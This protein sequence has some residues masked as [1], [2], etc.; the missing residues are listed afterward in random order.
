MQP[1]AILFDLDGTLVARGASIRNYATQFVADF[2]AKLST[3]DLDQILSVLI[4]A[5]GHG[6]RSLDRPI[7][8]AGT[9]LKGISASAADLHWRKYFPSSAVAAPM[10]TEV[11]AELKRRGI[12]TGL[13]TNG[14]V[15]AQRSKLETL[16]WTD[17]FVSLVI[18]EE[19]NFKKPD[20]R[21][22]ELALEQLK[23]HAA[24]TWF[25]GDHPINDIWG[26]NR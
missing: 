8:I 10:A 21:I 5:D 20:P 2:S 19:H 26:L 18:S 17:K 14:S 4:Q 13:V 9:L 16:G 24:R 1:E 22:F 11:L 7:E 15:L 25:V 3:T 23:T 6:Y 12:P